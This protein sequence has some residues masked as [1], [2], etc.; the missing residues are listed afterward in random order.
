MNENHPVGMLW[1]SP[2]NTWEDRQ[3]LIRDTAYSLIKGGAFW[4]HEINP[5]MYKLPEHI[6]TVEHMHRIGRMTVHAGKETMPGLC[7]LTDNES[8]F[9]QSN[10]NRLVYLMNYE[11]RRLHWTRAGM[12]SEIYHLDD[13]SHEKMPAHRV[14]MVTNAFCITDK[15][16]DNIIMFAR[17]NRAAVI[18]LVAPGIQTD[19]GFDLSRTSEITGFKI[20]SS[21]IECYPGI[22]LL[23]GRHPLSRP[24]SGDNNLLFQFGGG[25]N[26][27]DDSGAKS[28][29]PQFYIDA[30]GDNECVVLGMLSGLNEPGLAVK[31]MGD[32]TSIYC[33]APYVHN[34]FL[35]ATG[36]Y[37]GAH[38]YFD[39]DDAFH[40]SSELM[41]LN[42]RTAGTK[43]VLWH[44]PAEIAVDL[45]TGKVIA[46]KKEFLKFR[47]KTRESKFIFTGTEKKYTKIAKF[48]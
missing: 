11:A 30:Q 2:R 10:S 18:W 43:N 39:D 40:V 16:K 3:V 9:R 17:K 7:I 38:I 45:Y 31:D 29:G 4:W 14:L 28:T 35:R 15:Q 46:K 33:A 5:G 47:L 32:W 19:K 20:C 42:A 26:E 24:D 8:L 25:R 23:H 13:I 36:K 1:K 27:T 6:E 12:A 44:C 48:L 37:T 34:A 21:D 41:L 22:S